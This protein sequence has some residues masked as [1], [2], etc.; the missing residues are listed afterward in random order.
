MPKKTINFLLIFFYLSLIAGFF[1]NEDLNGG[2]RPDFEG[3]DKLI[4]NFADNFKETLLNFDDFNE[5]HSP[6]MLIIISSL[7][8][9]DFNLDSIRLLS[10]H[11][12]LLSIF[13][14][15]QCLRIKFSDVKIDYLILIS[16]IFFLSSNFRSLSIWP[17]SRAF[18]LLFLIL[19]IKYFLKFQIKN[20][21]RYIYK[22]IFF[23]ALS[24][25]FS[26]N[27]SLFAI[28]FFFH[29]LLITKEPK[30]FLKI[31]FLNILLASP[32]FYYIFILDV[33]FIKF[34]LTPGSSQ[35]IS[36]SSVEFNISNKILCITSIIFFYISPLLIYLNKID[37]QNKIKIIFLSIFFFIVYLFCIFNFNYQTLFTGGGIFFLISNYLFE[38]NFFLFVVCFF[39]FYFL[40]IKNFKFNNLFIIIILISS[41]P[42]LT[43][44]HKYY[45]PLIL[46]LMFSLFNFD[47]KKDFFN[48]KNILLIYLVYSLF[49][50]TKV[51]QK[52]L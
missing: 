16:L 2:A 49:I 32:A 40:F 51:G 30:I 34:G 29:F 42:Q 38:N 21:N 22:N 4:N 39:A 3:Y 45:D 23:L 50:L 12:N 41:N 35:N 8:K 18:G 14:F 48:K 44:Y 52:L 24:S 1:F 17:D 36:S 15:Y 26:P 9:L 13:F 20:E 46:V 28:Y 43:I 5:R 11:I 19:S 25:Y 33:N 27:F 7:T 6:L 10:L 47:L 37:Y 31:L